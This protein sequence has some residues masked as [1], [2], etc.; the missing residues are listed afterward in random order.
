MSANMILRLARANEIPERSLKRHKDDAQAVSERLGGL[1]EGG[2]WYWYL[3]DKLPKGVIAPQFEGDHA[4]ISVVSDGTQCFGTLRENPDSAYTTT[5]SA[6]RESM[7]AREGIAH[8]DEF[9]L[10][11]Q[12]AI[13]TNGAIHAGRVGILDGPMLDGELPY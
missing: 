6:N 7:R 2:R 1:A 9:R 5:K 11:T 4:Q 3:H 13:P 8:D 12:T 10:P